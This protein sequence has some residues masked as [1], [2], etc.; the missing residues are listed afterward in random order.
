MAIT[1][2]RLDELAKEKKDIYYSFYNK[3]SGEPVFCESNSEHS[4]TNGAS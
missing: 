3:E 2:L 1:I 4:E